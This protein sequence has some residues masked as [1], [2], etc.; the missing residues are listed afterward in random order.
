M[1]TAT[2]STRLSDIIA[3]E[4]SEGKRYSREEVTVA[5]GSNLVAGTVIGKRLFALE[6]VTAG[7]N[8]GNGTVD[9]PALGPQVKK[10]NY[11]LT[12]L[13]ASNFAVKA[14]DGTALPD[15][16]VGTAYSNEQISFT[17]TAGATAFAAGDTFT[18]SVIDGDGKVVAIDFDATDGTQRAYGVVIGDYDASSADVNGVAVVRHAI[19]ISKN[20][21]WPDTA[22]DEQ[23]AQALEELAQ[24]GILAR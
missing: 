24:K 15:A 17:I 12:A 21:V 11:V 19:V 8:T 7:S 5:S 13:D 18:I 16:K 22:T 6:G 4:D 9:D 23:K 10:G 20:L 2:L 3:W 14:P 1:P